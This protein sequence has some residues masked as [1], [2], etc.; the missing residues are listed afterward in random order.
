MTRAEAVALLGRAKWIMSDMQLSI[1]AG[2]AEHA[3]LLL[4]GSPHITLT[5]IRA[6]ADYVLP[7]GKR[8][9]VWLV[10]LQPPQARAKAFTAAVLRAIEK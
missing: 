7:P 4:L 1:E 8:G 3:E 5:E 2:E 10:L 6:L 9:H